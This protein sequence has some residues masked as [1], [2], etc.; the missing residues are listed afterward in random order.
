MPEEPA[1]VAL[2]AH[3]HRQVAAHTLGELLVCSTQLIRIESATILPSLLTDF[4]K[5]SSFPEAL[6]WKY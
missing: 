2:L 3:R 5:T 6:G 1:D 4:R